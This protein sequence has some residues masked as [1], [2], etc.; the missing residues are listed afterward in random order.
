MVAKYLTKDGKDWILET[1]IARLEGIGRF[2]IGLADEVKILEGEEAFDRAF[3]AYNHF[4]VLDF[5]LWEL[6]GTDESLFGWCF[7]WSET[8][9]EREYWKEIDRKWF[10]VCLNDVG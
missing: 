3:A 8:V 2:T 5:N 7:D 10:E 9:E 1:K 6:I 4:A